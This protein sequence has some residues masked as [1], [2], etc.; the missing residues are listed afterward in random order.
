MDGTEKSNLWPGGFYRVDAKGRETYVIQRMVRG[1]RYKVSTRTHSLRAAMKQL[2]RFEA[3]P[4]GYSPAG[5]QASLSGLELTT[6]LVAEFLRHSRDVD[7]NSKAWIRDQRRYLSKWVEVLKG[8]DLR[9]ISLTADIMV[10]LDG[11]TAQR[12]RIEVLKRLYSWLR[13]DVRRIKPTEDPTYG[14]LHVPQGRPEQ[15]ERTKA[16]S[17]E[18]F[19][20]LLPYLSGHWHAAV[21]VLGGT[22]WHV[23]EVLEFARGGSIEQHP[24]TDGDVLSCPRRKSGEPQRTEVSVEVGRA[25]EKLLANGAFNRSRLSRHIKEACKKAK[26]PPLNPGSMRHTVAT[27]AMNAGADPA[28]VAAFLGHKSESTTKRFYATHAIATKVPTLL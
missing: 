24:T 8:R 18:H 15:W 28:A 25:A 4:D 1:K 13:T 9:T 20:K 7:H 17:R 21:V 12:Q 22:G 27:W 10:A 11:A 6:E 23:S 14:T 26:V 2:E 3:D 16:Y 19:L 5:G